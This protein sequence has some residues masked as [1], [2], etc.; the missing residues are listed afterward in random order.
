[1]DFYSIFISILNHL[2][3]GKWVLLGQIVKGGSKYSDF[4][5]VFQWTLI[6]ILLINAVIINDN[7]FSN[8]MVLRR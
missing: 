3:P 6:R 4:F 7:A 5:T 8:F 2:S 1:M